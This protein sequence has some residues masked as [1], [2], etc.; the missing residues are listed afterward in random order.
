MTSLGQYVRHV[1]CR[2]HPKAAQDRRMLQ[3]HPIEARC[4]SQMLGTYWPFESFDTPSKM[5]DLAHCAWMIVPLDLPFRFD[6][7]LVVLVLIYYYGTDKAPLSPSGILRAGREVGPLGWKLTA[8]TAFRRLGAS[9]ASD[10]SEASENGR[11][12]E[13]SSYYFLLSIFHNNTTAPAKFK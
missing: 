5:S 6:P 11:T 8:L 13:L 2:W 1:L 3:F 4:S 10:A 9:A 12:R 7:G